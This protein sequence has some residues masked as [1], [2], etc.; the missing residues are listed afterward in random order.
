[1]TLNLSFIFLY[2]YLFIFSHSTFTLFSFLSLKFSQPNTRIKPKRKNKTKGCVQQWTQSQTIWEDTT[3][4]RYQSTCIKC[5]VNRKKSFSLRTWKRKGENQATQREN[6]HWF[7]LI[8]RVHLN[9]N[10]E[11]LNK[12]RANLP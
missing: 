7:S 11:S 2:F 8:G 3:H 12:M 6:Q 4:Y 5:V 9:L 1:M 10:R